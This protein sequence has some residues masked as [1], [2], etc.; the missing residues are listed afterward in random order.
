[1][2]ACFKQTIN[3]PAD[4]CG[5]GGGGGDGGCFGLLFVVVV[6][7]ANCKLQS[8]FFLGGVLFVCLFFVCLFGCFWFLFLFFVF[9]ANCNKVTKKRGDL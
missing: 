6:V 1:M 4:S 7:F 9:F 8:D 3:Q 2:T 5:G